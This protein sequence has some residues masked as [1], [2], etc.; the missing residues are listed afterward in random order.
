[1]SV[2]SYLRVLSVMGLRCLAELESC[3]GIPSR[4]AQLARSAKTYPELLCASSAAEAF[5]GILTVW[6][7]TWFRLPDLRG[8][9]AMLGLRRLEVMLLRHSHFR[10]SITGF[11]RYCGAIL[12]TLVGIAA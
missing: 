10:S 5:D 9:C 8:I 12:Q 7:S 11:R 3:V 6:L 2:G 4:G 1:M